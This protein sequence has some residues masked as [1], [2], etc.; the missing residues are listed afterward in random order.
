MTNLSWDLHVHP[1]PLSEG[2][3]GDAH[4]VRAAAA[5]A[6]LQGFV[7]KSHSAP[8]HPMV[9]HMPDAPPA[10]IA[11]ITLNSWA[12]PEAV[13]AAMNAGVRWIW[14]PSR[15]LDGSLAWDL[16]LPDWWP[17]VQAIVEQ[18]PGPVVL[19][20]SHLST[21]GRL[22]MAAFAASRPLTLCSVTHTM[23]VDP[24]EV[25]GLAD[26]QCMFEFD[27]YTW[28][29]PQAGRGDR[30]LLPQIDA[31][32]GAGAMPYVTT[33]AGQLSTGDPYLFSESRLQELNR[34]ADEDLVFDLCQRNPGLIVSGLYSGDASAWRGVTRR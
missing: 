27:L 15:A 32:L 22:E 33:D 5:R 20:T 21:D 26:M 25:R 30:V 7:W 8:V 18:V 31:V 6:G 23:Y 29:F 3:W 11:S 24:E 2:R 10:V 12:S 28:T 16:P 13:D 17:E 1:G 4:A 9:A 34:I 19:S 14:G